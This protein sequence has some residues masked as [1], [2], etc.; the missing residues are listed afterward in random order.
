MGDSWLHRWDSLRLFTPARYSGLPGFPFPG[1]DF[2]FPSREEAAGYLQRYARQFDLPLQFDTRADRLEREEGGRYLISAGEERFS[3]DRVVVATGAFRHP[4]I[5]DFAAELDPSIVQIH[6]SAYRNP[7]SLP[8]GN[9][10]VV[11]AGNSGAE[12][13]LE[14]RASGRHVRLSGR[15]PGVIPA[16]RLGRLFGGRPY[17]W[18]ISRLL[19]EDTPIGRK[20]KAK[21]LHHG[22]PWIRLKPEDLSRAGVERV[23][24]V[25]GVREGMPYLE[26]GQVLQPSAVLWATGFRPGFEWI[27]LPILDEHGY[28]RHD[29]GVAREAPR[30]YFV[31]LHFQHALTSALLGGVG[32]DAEYIAGRI[33]AEAGTAG[34]SLPV[35]S[36]S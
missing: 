11:G 13:A 5:P 7:A 36:I 21:S 29:R 34:E 1:A 3:A 22:S 17:W 10:L 24:R 23:P 19:S 14:I 31:G 25:A 28:P 16:D 9:V 30:L 26:D 33:H 4:A 8:D 32:A 20:L 15:G 27:S 18:M 6:S 12:I 35:K 2:S